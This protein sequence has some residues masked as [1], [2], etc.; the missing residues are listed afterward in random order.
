ML[1]FDYSDQ[2]VLFHEF[3]SWGLNADISLTLFQYG[4][5]SRPEAI[6]QAEFAL[7]VGVDTITFY[8]EYF[9]I[10]FPLKKQGTDQWRQLMQSSWFI[11]FNFT[12]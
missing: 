6:H 9:N 12:E 1:S 2:S 8:E 3:V 5:W 4:A 11:M 10:S 7:D